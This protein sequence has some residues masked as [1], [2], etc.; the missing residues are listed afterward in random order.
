MKC[1]A[2]A[3]VACGREGRLEH[4]VTRVSGLGLGHVQ[5]TWRP[6]RA[7][8]MGTRGRE[9]RLR[10]STGAVVWTKGRNELTHKSGQRYSG[11]AVAN[12]FFLE[13]GHYLYFPYMHRSMTEWRQPDSVL[14]FLL[15]QGVSEKF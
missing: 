6:W 2:E 14:E 3:I 12:T 4:G 10:A 13:R 8:E 15:S 1:G 11:D 5:P 7:A 9:C